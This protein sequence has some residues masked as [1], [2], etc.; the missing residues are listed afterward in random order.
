MSR[1]LSEQ[2]TATSKATGQRCRRRVIGGGVCIMHGGSAPQV[3][4]AREVRILA[5]EAAMEAP[6]SAADAADVMTSAMND[7]HSLLQ[8]LKV[9][10][11]DGRITGAD[12]R[13]LGEWVDRA[14]RASNLVM[15]AG[16]EE[17]RVLISEA[18]A[19]EFLLALE[20]LMDLLSLTP[21]QRRRVPFELPKV[22]ASI[23]AER[24]QAFPSVPSITRLLDT[25]LA[26]SRDRIAAGD[27]RLLA[28]VIG[29][30]L[31]RL[32][33]SVEQQALVPV[34]VPAE[35]RAVA[36]GQVGS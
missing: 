12:L 23:D 6:Q 17:R 8:R 9:N 20:R 19:R 18:T 22:M 7:A 34:V 33:L 29:R 4:A 27:G 36:E 35:L 21:E 14:M 31:V 16:L 3:R 24:A 11:A 5:A 13:A 1:V 15:N 25:E 2:C 10:I 26:E 30:I 32:E 28:G